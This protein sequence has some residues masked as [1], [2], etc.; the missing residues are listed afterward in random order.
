MAA[1]KHKKASRIIKT[2][3]KLAALNEGRF[4]SIYRRGGHR[5][6]TF[7]TNSG[8]SVCCGITQNLV[9]KMLSEVFLDKMSYIEVELE[10]I[11]QRYCLNVKYKLSMIKNIS[12]NE[13]SEIEKR[14]DREKVFVELQ[15]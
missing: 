10:T 14:L 4:R 13:W 8:N 5:Y 9:E 15:K 7:W 3:Y 11:D 6:I 2:V 12:W 1:S